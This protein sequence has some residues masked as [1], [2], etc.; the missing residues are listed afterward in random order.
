[1]QDIQ[2]WDNWYGGT[3]AIVG[4]LAYCTYLILSGT[5]QGVALVTVQGT[6]NGD[7]VKA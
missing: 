1:M 4:Q 7:A 2:L 5:D 3:Y 6:D